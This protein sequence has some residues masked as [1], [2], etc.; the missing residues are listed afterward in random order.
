MTDPAAANATLIAFLEEHEEE[1]AE[2][3]RQFEASELE[4]L[5]REA[6]EQLAKYSDAQ[7]GE[8]LL[9]LC[10]TQ[11]LIDM[12]EIHNILIH[13]PNVS[14][15]QADGGICALHVACRGDDETMM[16]DIVELLIN[17][18]ADVNAATY[19]LESNE[20]E[21]QPVF[22]TPLMEASYFGNTGIVQMLLNARA[23]IHAKTKNGTTALEVAIDQDQEGSHDECV[24]L[25]RACG[26]VD[27]REAG[28]GAA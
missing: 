11:R 5:K 4:E 20:A 22:W 26:A 3:Q 17:H 27:W 1:I 12:P 25:L 16:D 24:K 15:Y 6:S 14:T 19:Y 2:A 8:K 10:Y 9:E 21:Q 13:R 18:G 7:L 23:N 28:A